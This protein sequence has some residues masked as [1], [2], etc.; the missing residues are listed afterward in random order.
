MS[1]A[2][3][4]E[5]DLK[6]YYV[7]FPL[8]LPAGDTETRTSAYTQRTQTVTEW[9]ELAIAPQPPRATVAPEA[10]SSRGLGRRAGAA[11][12]GQAVSVTI[13]LRNLAWF[14]I[15]SAARIATINPPNAVSPYAVMFI[16]YGM[17]AAAHLALCTWMMSAQFKRVRNV[18]PFL[19]IFAGCFPVGLVMFAIA[20]GVAGSRWLADAAVWLTIAAAFV[21]LIALDTCAPSYHDQ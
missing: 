2:F 12:L 11:A 13:L 21:L 9:K 16:V 5:P 19:P 8:D 6:R 14:V 4:N 15:F 7:A 3:E 18:D 1:R 17:G 20:F 10:G